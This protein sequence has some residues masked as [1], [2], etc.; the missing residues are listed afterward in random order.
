MDNNVEYLGDGLYVRNDGWQLILMANS[1]EHP[2][3]TVA[4]DGHT[5]ANFLKYVKRLEEKEEAEDG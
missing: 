1:H 4:L 3:D 5:L 2:T